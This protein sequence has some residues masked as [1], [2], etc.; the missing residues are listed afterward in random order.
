MVI[1]DSDSKVA[2]VIDV[3]NCQGHEV[4]REYYRNPAM[5]KI[6]KGKEPIDGIFLDMNFALMEGCPIEKDLGLDYVLEEMKRIEIDIPVC[7]FSSNEYEEDKF[8]E[9]ENVVQYIQYDAFVY[10]RK[11][12]ESAV[13]KFKEY[14]EN[15]RR[16]EKDEET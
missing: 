4:V 5:Y 7:V 6:V 11:K 12:I 10:I 2:E 13:E 9:F 16:S 3:L 1:D 15:K 8:K 14:N